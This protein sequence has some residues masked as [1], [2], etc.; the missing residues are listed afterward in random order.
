VIEGF[1]CEGGATLDVE[2]LEGGL[3]MAE[4]LI[5]EEGAEANI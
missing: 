4:G 5:G 2:E 3:D 1:V